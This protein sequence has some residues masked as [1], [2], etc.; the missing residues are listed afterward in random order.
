MNFKQ[1]K[2][3]QKLWLPLI[4]ALFITIAFLRSDLLISKTNKLL[5]PL[6][7]KIYT[8]TNNLQ[9]F[10]D[11]FFYVK[12]INKKNESLRLTIEKQKHLFIENKNLLE[13]N[14]HLR[15]LL[16]MK[17]KTKYEIIVAQVSYIDSLNPYETISID[18]GVNDGI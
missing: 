11:T 5:L 16:Q 17:K 2:S 4:V 15:E 13:E 6:R 14:Q 3:K 9:N 10:F 12:E 18:K 8:T 7:I 1:K